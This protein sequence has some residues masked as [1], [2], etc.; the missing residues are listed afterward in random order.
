M[1]TSYDD[2]PRGTGHGDGTDTSVAGATVSVDLKDLIAMPD[3]H[4]LQLFANPGMTAH[5]AVEF[6]RAGAEALAD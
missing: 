4:V 6:E 3:M 1:I 2:L 5:E